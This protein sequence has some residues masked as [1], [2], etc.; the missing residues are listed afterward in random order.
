MNVINLAY[1][2]RACT[3][4]L[5]GSDGAHDPQPA[6]R[7]PYSVIGADQSHEEGVWSPCAAGQ[8]SMATPTIRELRRPPTARS[9]DGPSPPSTLVA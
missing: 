8:G 1:K 5:P 9:P 3:T 7:A 6:M 2:D 4:G